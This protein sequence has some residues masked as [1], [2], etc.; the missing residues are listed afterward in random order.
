MHTDRSASEPPQPVA[1]H[2]S[3]GRTVMSARMRSLH[4]AVLRSPFQP[5]LPWLA[6]SFASILTAVVHAAPPIP[7]TATPLSAAEATRLVSSRSSGPL[8]VTATAIDAPAAAV[9]AAWQGELVI[10]RLAS[11]DAGVATALGRHRGPLSL[12]GVRSLTPDAAGGLAAHGSILWLDGLS[13]L[14]TATASALAQ[15][16]GPLV[17][18]GLTVLAPAAAAALA[19]HTAWLPLAALDSPDVPLARA[20]AMHEGPLSLDGIVQLAPPVAAE[21]ARVRHPLSLGGVVALSP[22]TAR[23]L[24]RH[25]AYL[26]L[27]RLAAFPPAVARSLAAHRGGIMLPPRC[28]ISYDSAVVLGSSWNPQALT[29]IDFNA[30]ADR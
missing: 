18:D 17:L 11:L 27:P 26:A 30:K 2:V 1:K 14:G 23:E 29:G 12:G 25:A 4:A 3:E 15:H 5:T 20:L 8:I 6:V 22:R 13:T 28:A 16:Q 10:D 24:S 21:L 9:L 19:R 7:A